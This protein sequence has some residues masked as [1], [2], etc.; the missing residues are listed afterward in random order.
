M[1]DTFND[2]RLPERFWV[3]VDHDPAGCWRWRAAINQGYGFFLWAGRS[4]NAHRVAYEALVGPIPKGHVVDHDC[5]N[6]TGCPG[7]VDCPHRRCVRPSH[8][9]AVTQSINKQRGMSFAAQ[10]SRHTHC[11]REGHEL[12]GRNLM[13]NR[14]GHRECRA[15]KYART[16]ARR[17]RLRAEH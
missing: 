10:R 13:V 9:E 15:C 11:A 1:T 7:G 5:H 2:P 8:L 14:R 17:A 16:A 12:A 3:K 4:Q 6:G